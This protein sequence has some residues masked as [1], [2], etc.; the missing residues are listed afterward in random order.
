MAE[1]YTITCTDQPEWDIIG[2]GIPDFNRQQG[3][4]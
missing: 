1:E 2:G 3:G 4:E